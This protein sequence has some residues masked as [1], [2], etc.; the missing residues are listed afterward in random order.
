M[1]EFVRRMQQ[2]LFEILREARSLEGLRWVE[3]KARAMR[4]NM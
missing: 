1:S 2:V 3:P 4:R